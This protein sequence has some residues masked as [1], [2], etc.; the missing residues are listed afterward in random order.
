MQKT[1]RKIIAKETLEIIEQGFYE[2]EKLKKIDISEIQKYVVD[3]TK[4]YD[5]TQLDKLLK[6]QD[7]K[8][9]YDTSFKVIEET[10]IHGIQRI[11]SLGFENPMCLN[12]ASAKNPGGGFLMVLRHRKKVLPDHQG[13]TLVN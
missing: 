8:E 13:Y 10:T 1:L 6:E 5:T 7:I 4:F 12:F 11:T 2:N 3:N 9:K